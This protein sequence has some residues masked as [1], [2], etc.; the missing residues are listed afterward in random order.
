[1]F[2]L[3]VGVNIFSYADCVAPPAFSIKPSA[4]VK[5][6]EPF[7]ANTITLLRASVEPKS[8]AIVSA[9][10]PVFSFISDKNFDQPTLCKC[11]DE[12][13]SPNFFAVFPASADGFKILLYAAFNP[14]TASLVP[15]PF[16]VRTAILLNNSLVDTFRLEAIGITFPML[17][18][19]SPNDVFP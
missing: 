4:S 16:F 8:L 1:M 2:I 10:P 19:I 18:A 15:I 6:D 11:A 13:S 3:S 5:S 12:K 9:F 7:P 14:V 17:L